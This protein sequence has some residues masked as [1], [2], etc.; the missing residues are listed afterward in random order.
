MVRPAFND[1]LEVRQQYLSM[2]FHKIP[3]EAAWTLLD[4]GRVATPAQTADE[5]S[6]NRI[7]DKNTL[8][9]AGQ[10]ATDVTINL[11]VEDDIEELGR[12]LG[13]VMP[14]GG[15]TGAEVIELDPTKVADLKIVNYDGITL[16]ANV[17]FTEYINRFKPSKFSIPEDAEGDVRIAELSGSAEAY[18]ILPEAGLGAP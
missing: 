18:Y 2:V 7:G 11:Y 13:T 5:K 8:K 17:L 10:I 4:Q 1:A 15:W 12:I 9:V 6:Y 3:G 14:G 16:A